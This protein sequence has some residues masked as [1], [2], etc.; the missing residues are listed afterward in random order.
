MKIEILNPETLQNLY[1][2][3]GEFACTCY[4][5]PVKYAEKVGK[6]CCKASGHASG[7]RC[8]YIKFRIEGIDRG[9]AEQLMRHEIGTRYNPV[10]KYEAHIDKTGFTYTT[11]RNILKSDRASKRYNE[12]MCCIDDVRMDIKRILLEEGVDYKKA[13]EDANFVLP[14][15][16]ALTLTIAFTPEALIQ[17]MWKRLCVRAQDEIREVALKMKEEVNKINPEFAKELTPHCQHL[18]WC[19]EGNMSCGAYSTKEELMNKISSK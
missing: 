8:E 10:D 14:R 3:H 4:D 9:T 11:P 2:N 5:T 1:K 18:L 19:P 17:L 7:S 16:T 15:A 13:V 6:A 12:L